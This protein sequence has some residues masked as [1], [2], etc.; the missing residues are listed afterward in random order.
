MSPSP[1]LAAYLAPACQR[2]AL[3]MGDHAW[4]VELLEWTASLPLPRGEHLLLHANLQAC[5]GKTSSAQRLLQ[6]ILCG[7]VQTAVVPTLVD[8]WLL[9]AQLAHRVADTHRAHEALTQALA[10]AA[11]HHTLRP[12]HEA[13]ESI[14]T[15]LANGI[16]RFGQLESFAATV[17]D[18][19][20]ASAPTLIDGLTERERD[21]LVELPSMRTVE[22]IAESLFVSVNTVK[23][24]LRGIYRK[25]GVNRRRDAV[26]VARQRGLL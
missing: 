23:S 8:A 4:A 10:I 24:H 2:M 6:P 16:G 22:E 15:V 11:P 9:E 20:P 25:L 18:T 5:D 26:A 19:L 12:F 21:L 13:G 14:R 17:L 3:R 7:K 1:V